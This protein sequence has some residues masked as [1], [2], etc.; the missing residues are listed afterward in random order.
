MEIRLICT[1]TLGK[2][3]KKES[4]RWKGCQATQT[5]FYFFFVEWY[6]KIFN[7]ISFKIIIFFAGRS[8][9]IWKPLQIATY[10]IY[11]L[12]SIAII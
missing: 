12:P 5:T 3:Q 8:H 11:Y 9:T 4:C 7:F 10:T 1:Y 6:Y 2:G